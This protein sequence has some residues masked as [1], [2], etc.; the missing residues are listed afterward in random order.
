MDKHRVYKMVFAGVYPH[1]V[2]KVEK[3]GRT[4]KELDEV[5]CSHR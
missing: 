2:H 4:K 1:Y 5:I 3:K